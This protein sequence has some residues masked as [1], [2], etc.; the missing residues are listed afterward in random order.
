MYL[1]QVQESHTLR[2]S[3]SN[4]SGFISKTTPLQGELIWFWGDTHIKYLLDNEFLWN[5]DAY[6][7]YVKVTS[8]NLDS[9]ANPYVQKNL[10]GS[11]SMFS[12]EEFIHIVMLHPI[13]VL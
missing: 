13:E 2:H 11:F 8:A 4:G 6:N 5:K 1:I 10:D 9:D 7:L 3:F 12:M